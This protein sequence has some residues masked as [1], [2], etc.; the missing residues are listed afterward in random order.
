[1]LHLKWIIT[2]AC[3]TFIA[4][5]NGVLASSVMD[6]GSIKFDCPDTS[7]FAITYST[8]NIESINLNI[9]LPATAEP[10]GVWTSPFGNLVSGGW[11]SPATNVSGVY[12]YS[13]ID[14]DGCLLYGTLALI[15]TTDSDSDGICDDSEIVG[16]QDPTADNYNPDA[17]DPGPCGQLAV[18]PDGPSTISFPIGSS[19]SGR[20]SP[21]FTA[22]PNPLKEGDLTIQFSGSSSGGRVVV[23]DLLG[24]VVFQ[25]VV[26][27]EQNLLTIP[28]SHFIAAGVYL[29]SFKDFDGSSSHQKV[30]VAK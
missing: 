12:S 16:C 18:Q 14:S 7:L 1:M 30:M 9:Y 13:W 2:L 25:D 15:F 10:S 8:C 19:L 21:G 20:P 3:F 11:V 6:K 17:T 28:A 22:F 5:S 23:Y 26:P 4:L 24:K 27:N 29:V